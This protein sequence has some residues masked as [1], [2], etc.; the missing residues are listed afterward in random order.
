MRHPKFRGFF[1]TYLL[2]LA[3]AMLL[4]AVIALLLRGRLA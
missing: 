3:A 2:A 1:L 4:A